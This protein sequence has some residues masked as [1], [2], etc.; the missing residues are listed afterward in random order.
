MFKKQKYYLEQSLNF[1]N[2]YR[3]PKTME[4]SSLLYTAD[5]PEI[6]IKTVHVFAVYNV[7]AL[8][9]ACFLSKKI[10]EIIEINISF[11]QNEKVAYLVFLKKNLCSKWYNVCRGE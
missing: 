3:V 5:Q 6:K 1:D 9:S 7:S 4:D 11:C 8:K 10:K 2:R